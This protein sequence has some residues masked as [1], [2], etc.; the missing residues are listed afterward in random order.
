[1]PSIIVIDDPAL[2]CI[3]QDILGILNLANVDCHLVTLADFKAAL[4]GTR[5]AQV[6]ITGVGVRFDADLFDAMPNLRAV[7]SAVVGVDAVDLAAAAQ[8]GIAVAN[9]PAVEASES[10]AEA[11]ILLIL[12]C[13]YDLPGNQK[14]LRENA[15][16][17]LRPT[18]RMLKSRS[19]GLVGF[20]RTAQEVAMRLRPWGIAIYAYVRS[21]RPA[22]EGVHYVALDTLLRSCDVVSVHAAL[23]EGSRNLLGEPQLASMKPGSVLVNTSRGGIVDEAALARLCQQGHIS[24]VGLDVFAQEPLP[25]DSPLRSL[26]RSVLTQ[27]RLGHTAESYAA[28]VSAAVGNAQDAL[29]GRSLRNS[30]MPAQMPF[31]MTA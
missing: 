25:M 4:P 23:N 16:R 21:P 6:V 28:L 15:S 18:G 14:L 9:S 1:M 2:G 30:V 8:R 20:G 7:V 31:P 5:S 24:A 11:T 12:A 13:L 3:P 17:P 10:L 19:L 26:E 22:V 27:H 29:A